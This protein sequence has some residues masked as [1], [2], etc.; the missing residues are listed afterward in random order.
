M[1]WH[2]VDG[3]PQ[4]DWRNC[5]F[6]LDGVALT[7]MDMSMHMLGVM[8][9]P[10]DDLTL[11]AMMPWV[12]NEMDHVTA[13]GGAFTTES[14]HLAGPSRRATGNRQRVNGRLAERFVT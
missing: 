11:V 2:W 12:E 6:C 1:C 13:T 8:Y 5:V 14:S 7:Q 3:D 4:E 10:S 9:A